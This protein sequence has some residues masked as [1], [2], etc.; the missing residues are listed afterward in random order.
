LGGGGKGPDKKNVLTSQEETLRRRERRGGG[1]Q[2]RERKE[3]WGNI[4]ENLRKGVEKGK[5]Q[6]IRVADSD[7]A[8]KHSH[9]S[10]K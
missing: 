8:S 2:R 1:N 10:R 7:T 3:T 6:F 4:G 9:N 5:E